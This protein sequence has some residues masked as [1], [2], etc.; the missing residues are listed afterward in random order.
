MGL[1]A[2]LE[3]R[4]ESCASEAEL[5]SLLLS[6]R[7]L[8]GEPQSGRSRRKRFVVAREYAASP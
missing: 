1:S 4:P 5:C 3:K 6:A 8:L 2:G 7:F